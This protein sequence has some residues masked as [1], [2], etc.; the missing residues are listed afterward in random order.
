M[1]VYGCFHIPFNCVF[2][3]PIVLY[4]LRSSNPV[5]FMALFHLT[6]PLNIINFYSD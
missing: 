5:D 1:T 6:V 3:A 4:Y 2:A